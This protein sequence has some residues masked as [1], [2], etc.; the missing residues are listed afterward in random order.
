MGG[1]ACCLWLPEDRQLSSEVK[2]DG[3]DAQ[4]TRERRTEPTPTL[5]TK[6]VVWPRDSLPVPEPLR[7]LD[8]GIL[9]NSGLRTF[10]EVT[11]ERE[12]L[13]ADRYRPV[14]E[15]AILRA[16]HEYDETEIQPHQVF[17]AG[18]VPC[19]LVDPANVTD[20][21]ILWPALAMGRSRA[22]PLAKPRLCVY[23]PGS[24]V[25]A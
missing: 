19:Q 25:G 13:H 23:P 18:G 2:L 1:G 21:A 20:N 9:K 14:S 17:R 7:A 4:T 8:G 6:D 24:S 12:P 22:R 10:T 16:D 15:G 3:S 11:S 5:P